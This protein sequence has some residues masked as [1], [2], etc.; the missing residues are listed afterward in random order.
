MGTGHVLGQ[1]PK[2]GEWQGEPGGWWGL[3]VVRVPS[4][5][6]GRAEPRYDTAPL[7][8][9]IYIFASPLGWLGARLRET[10]SGR[11]RKTTALAYLWGQGSY[12]FFTHWDSR[13]LVLSN[14]GGPWGASTPTAN[15]GRHPRSPCNR[16]CTTG[17]SWS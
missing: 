4:A 5:T 9:P 13:V 2:S 1:L 3:G 17:T 14:G 12:S 7:R 15:V 10:G 8:V 6:A 16:P 11:C